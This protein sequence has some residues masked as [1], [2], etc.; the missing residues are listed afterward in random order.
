MNEI[1]RAIERFEEIILHLEKS[2]CAQSK[3]EDHKLALTAL[4]EKLS[5][6]ENAP[7]THNEMIDI[8]DNPNQLGAHVW[9]KRIRDGVIIAAVTDITRDG[10]IAVWSPN[11]KSDHETGLLGYFT[12]ANYGKT[13]L[14]YRYEPKGEKECTTD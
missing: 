7:L 10:F 11:Q 2:V 1:E 14:A 9:V 4:K 8:S 12:E 6:Q 13:W 3:L 5:R